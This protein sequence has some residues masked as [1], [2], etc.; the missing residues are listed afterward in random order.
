[1]PQNLK[2]TTGN[3]KN[4]R[5][6]FLAENKDLKTGRQ[7]RNIGSACFFLCS[8]RLKRKYPGNCL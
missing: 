1:L 5:G 8:L 7:F 3:L 6:N 2:S 4:F